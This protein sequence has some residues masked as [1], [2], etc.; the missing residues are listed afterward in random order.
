MVVVM[1]IMALLGIIGVSALVSTQK[2]QRAE[3]AKEQFLGEIQKTKFYAIETKQA[4]DDCSPA[5]WA[6]VVEKV[7]GDDN[8]KISRYRYCNDDGPD[9]EWRTSASTYGSGI[10]GDLNQAFPSEISIK[11][12]TSGANFDQITLIYTVPTGKYYQITGA[13]NNGLD[14][15]DNPKFESIQPSGTVTAD[16]EFSFTINGTSTSVTINGGT[17]AVL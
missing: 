15:P 10:S 5:M 17:G 3:G 4:E 14:I 9:G 7:P 12:V 2:Q 11:N 13:L 8:D 1:G 16:F 6:L